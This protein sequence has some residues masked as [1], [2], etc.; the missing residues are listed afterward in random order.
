M[1]EKLEKISC[2]V[3]KDLIPSYIDEICSE[4]SRNLVDEHIKSCTD[5]HTHLELLQNTTLTDEKGEKE[6][7]SYLKKIKKLYA[8]RQIISL[9]FLMMTV[10]GSFKIIIDNYGSGGEILLYTI[11]PILIIAACCLAQDSGQM[12]K[13]S[14]LSLI[15]I[16]VSIVLTLYCI[17]LMFFGISMILNA[18][19]QD[20]IVPFGLS[21]DK[22]GPFFS[23]QLYTIIVL[24]SGIFVLSNVLSLN[25]IRVNKYIYGITLT[26]AY[27]AVGYIC[28]Q[29]NLSTPETYPTALFGM[30]I[31]LTIEGIISSAIGIAFARKMLC[32]SD[33]VA[34]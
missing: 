9:A 23:S 17:G 19:D 34:L 27:M 15:L 21:P 12:A 30:T 32:K 31:Y 33:I 8:K 29:K 5:C 13:Q 28:L 6:K 7:I 10:I 22:V 20:F 25:G 3:I 26:C 11:V 24:Q 18:F 16:F 1:Q 2:N 4:E 14:K